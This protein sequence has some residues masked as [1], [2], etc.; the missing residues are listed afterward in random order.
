MEEDGQ[1]VVSRDRTV[2]QDPFLFHGKDEISPSHEKE[3]DV[4]L[5]RIIVHETDDWP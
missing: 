2:N 3:T 4:R 1:S 5:A